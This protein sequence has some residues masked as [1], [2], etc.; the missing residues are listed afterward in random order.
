MP[1]LE[2]NGG[3]RALFACQVCGEEFGAGE[4]NRGRCPHCLKGYGD[5]IGECPDDPDDS[6][7][8]V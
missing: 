2:M 8:K 5:P 4:E 1:D 7:T 3:K 6:L